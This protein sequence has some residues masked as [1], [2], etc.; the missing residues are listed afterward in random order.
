[1]CLVRVDRVDRVASAG[2]GVMRMAFPE[3]GLGWERC[4]VYVWRNKDWVPFW[5]CVQV[6]N[7]QKRGVYFPC[8]RGRRFP[9]V[10]E[11][12]AGSHPGQLGP[13][14]VIFL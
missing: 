3:E 7:N 8:F 10:I 4:C 12:R 11:N 9:Y 14:S 13:S 5:S 2:L 6:E 1:V